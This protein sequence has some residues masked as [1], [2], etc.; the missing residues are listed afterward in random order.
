ME[1]ADSR[2]Q[3]VV[4]GL[5]FSWGRFPPEDCGKRMPPLNATR[6]PLEE[7]CDRL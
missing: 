2:T 3:F 5:F 1:E 4:D 6:L 7:A